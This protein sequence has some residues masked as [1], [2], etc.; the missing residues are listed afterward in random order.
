MSKGVSMLLKIADFSAPPI[1]C[2]PVVRMLSG[3][4]FRRCQDKENNATQL[5]NNMVSRY[6][7]S[8]NVFYELLTTN[9]LR[10]LYLPFDHV[11]DPKL[12]S[13]KL[14]LD[15]KKRGELFPP[16]VTTE[17]FSGHEARMATPGA[18][19]SG[20]TRAIISCRAHHRDPLFDCMKGAN[21]DRIIL[22]SGSGKTD[23]T[24]GFRAISCASVFV[25][26]AANPKKA[27]RNKVKFGAFFKS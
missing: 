10:T 27:F 13:G 26:R 23:T 22:K 5:F 16:S 17:S 3:G 25:K 1:G 18:A 24:P 15:V 7:L 19:T 21:G 20:C 14:P 12:S 11:I 2:N 4:A 8:R 6:T 9:G